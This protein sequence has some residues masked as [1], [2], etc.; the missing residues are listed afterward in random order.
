MDKSPLYDRVII[1]LDMNAFFA[2]VEQ[3]SNPKLMG[4]PVI[5]GGDPGSRT[6]VA[7]A[8][9]E[10]RAYGVKA[11]MPLK[12]AL[13]LC[14][15]A[16]LVVG[17]MAKYEY[18]SARV[19]KL[20]SEFSPLVEVFSIDE[21]FMDITG[22]H[23]LFGG[24]ERLAEKLQRR[25]KTELGLSCSIGIAPNKLLAKLASDMKKPDGLVKILPEEIENL[26]EKLP[27]DKL[28]GIGDKLSADLNLLGIKT[29]G[30]LG[31]Y[32]PEKLAARYGLNGEKLWQMGR[33]QDMS[34]VV[35]LYHETEVKSVGH[36]HTLSRDTSNRLILRGLLR[37]LSEMVGRR[38]RCGGWQGR[39]VSLVVRLGDFT[40]FGRQKALPYHIDSGAEIMRQAWGIFESFSLKR[41]VRL[42][43]VSVAQLI[44]N[45]QQVGLF[46]PER[47]NRQLQ[48]TLDAINDRWGENMIHPAV[49]EVE[50][51]GRSRVGWQ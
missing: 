19:F 2:S 20:M 36:S 50:N 46:E 26:L 21:A 8:S 12:Q 28:C 49:T 34:P 22:T 31:C 29:C 30:Q 32:P 15:Q 6:V 4:R 35:P 27:V 24:P 16:V 9:Y 45:A 42:L 43:G 11:A 18:T 3:R 1:H 39:V 10:A 47:A 41:P 25:L 17:D 23:L 40:T 48:E 44:R 37:R 5:V 51:D 33:G 7:A 13:R 14:P 38:L